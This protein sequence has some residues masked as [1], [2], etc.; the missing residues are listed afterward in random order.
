MFAEEVCLG[1]PPDLV[2][3]KKKRHLV[4]KI[5]VEKPYFIFHG[6]VTGHNKSAKF[7]IK[8]VMRELNTWLHLLTSSLFLI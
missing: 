8:I 5:S 4:K 7:D 3:Q 6:N 2:I 1:E